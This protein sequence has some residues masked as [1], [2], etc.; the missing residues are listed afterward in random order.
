MVVTTY[1][2][3]IASRPR[4]C[5]GCGR[6]IFP[7]EIYLL[8]KQVMTFKKMRATISR[9]YCLKCAKNIVVNGENVLDV[10]LRNRV[11]ELKIRIDRK[12]RV[13]KT[14]NDVLGEDVY[15]KIVEYLSYT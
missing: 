10:L 9:A 7:R 5:D 11:R 12:N 1:R 14:M 15:R 2:I 13:T 8:N 6:A 4:K 3:T